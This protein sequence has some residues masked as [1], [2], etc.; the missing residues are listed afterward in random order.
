MPSEVGFWELVRSGASEE[1]G[2]VGTRQSKVI[3]ERNQ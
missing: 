3:M 1:H 2:K